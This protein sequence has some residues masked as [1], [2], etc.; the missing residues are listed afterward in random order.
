M[1]V[2]LWLLYFLH[3]NKHI[4]EDKLYLDIFFGEYDMRDNEKFIVGFHNK[5]FID[6][7]VNLYINLAEFVI[8]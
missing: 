2:F 1:N 5:L 6:L 4:W 8:C 3:Q 7:I